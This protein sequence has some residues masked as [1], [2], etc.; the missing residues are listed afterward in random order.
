MA[1]PAPTVADALQY[2]RTLRRDGYIL[3]IEREGLPA[4]I[5]A[6]THSMDA[7][8]RGATSKAVQ[9]AAGE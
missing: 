1:C 5:P 6:T 9:R 8:L 2:C 3:W 4:T 7:W